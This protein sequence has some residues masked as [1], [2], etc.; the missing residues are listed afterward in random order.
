VGVTAPHA[1]DPWREAASAVAHYRYLHPLDPRQTQPSATQTRICVEVAAAPQP[2]LILHG[3]RL[4]NPDE[5]ASGVIGSR[6]A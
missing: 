1:P 6:A 2:L 3:S 4:V 5:V